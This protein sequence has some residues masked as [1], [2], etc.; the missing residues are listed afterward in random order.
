MLTPKDYETDGKVPRILRGKVKTIEVID[1]HTAVRLSTKSAILQALMSNACE[2]WLSNEDI[3]EVLA[4]AYE[5]RT[6]MSVM[7]L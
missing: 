6:A 3:Q 7:E 5:E 1:R 2:R 4:D